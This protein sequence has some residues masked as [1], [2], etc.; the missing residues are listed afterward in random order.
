MNDDAPQ[1]PPPPD[2]AARP[3]AYL[4]GFMGTGKSTYGRRLAA[5][6]GMRFLDVDEEIEKAAGC[7]IREIFA[8]EGE[9]AFRTRERE[10]IT[11]GHPARGCIVA[12]GGGLPCQPGM[13]DIL[14]RR[15]VVIALFA[16][17]ETI[18]ERTAHNK[19][20]PLLNVDDPAARIRALL[21]ERLPVYQDAGPGLSTDHRPTAEI[22][23]HLERIYTAE[24]ARFESAS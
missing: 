1:S 7:P 11:A 21:D 24:A 22:L 16:S 23:D 3:N 2:G 17:P 10:W 15:G 13:L 6:L 20:R 9:A 12:T 14:H 19:D 4:V 18:L 5:R 8:S